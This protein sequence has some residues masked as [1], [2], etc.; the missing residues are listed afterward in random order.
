MST[1]SLSMSHARA[2]GAV[3]HGSA[4]APCRLECRLVAVSV[5]LGLGPAAPIRARTVQG[6]VADWLSIL[7]CTRKRWIVCLIQDA[8]GVSMSALTESRAPVPSVA[9]PG[10]SPRRMAVSGSNVGTELAD[11]HSRSITCCSTTSTV[12]DVTVMKQDWYLT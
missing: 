2:K 1:I 6:C 11:H 8:V 9:H 5:Y 3:L 12:T 10:H 7:K 4:V